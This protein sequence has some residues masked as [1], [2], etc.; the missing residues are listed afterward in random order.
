MMLTSLGAKAN[1]LDF[2]QETFARGL[3]VAADTRDRV[4]CQK[5]KEL[6]GSLM[7]LEEDL[8]AID[9]LNPISVVVMT[10]P[11]DEWDFMAEIDSSRNAPRSIRDSNVGF[12]RGGRTSLLFL[13]PSARES[14]NM[15]RVAVRREQ[16]TIAQVRV[17]DLS[18]LQEMQRGH[19][20]VHFTLRNIPRDLSERDRSAAERIVRR[21]RIRSSNI[22]GLTKEKTI[23]QSLN[24]VDNINSSI[25]DPESPD[26]FEMGFFLPEGLCLSLKKC[27][28]GGDDEDGSFF[29]LSLGFSFKIR[30]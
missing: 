12:V 11:V 3:M 28:N 16:A 10:I 17:S 23:L 13:L 9:E 27:L 20:F 1:T 22:E 6:V 14:N 5:T 7:R 21:V 15:I 4:G 25:N 30:F 29:P 2:Q 8:C 24:I 18:M 26:R 19:T